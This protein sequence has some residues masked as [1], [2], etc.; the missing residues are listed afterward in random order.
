M[1][2]A[3][4]NFPFSDMSGWTLCRDRLRAHVGFLTSRVSV[5][6]TNLHLGHYQRVAFWN[7]QSR[8]ERRGGGGEAEP[9]SLDRLAR[10]ALLVHQYLGLANQQG[11]KGHKKKKHNQNYRSGAPVGALTIDLRKPCPVFAHRL[12]FCIYVSAGSS[13]RTSTREAHRPAVE[14]AV[15][16]FEAVRHHILTHVGRVCVVVVA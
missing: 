15:A 8:L 9:Y 11:L 2:A 1:L 16:E 6:S 7:S 4:V 14:R 5:R 13:T 3:K 12:A 10:V